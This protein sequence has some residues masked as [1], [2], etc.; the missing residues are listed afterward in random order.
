MKKLTTQEW[1]EK[2]RKIHGDKFDYSQTQYLTAKIPIKIICP[3]HGAFYTLPHNHLKPN[4]GC[5]KCRYESSTVKQAKSKDQFIKDA[6]FVHGDKYDYS[7]VKYVNNTTK[8]CIICPI[9]GEFW[10]APTKH[11]DAKQGCPSCSGNKKRSTESFIADAIKIHGNKYDYSKV[12]YKGAHTHVVITCPKHGDF[13]QCPNEHLHGQGCP[14]CKETKGEKEI[15]QM[16]DKLNIKYEYQYKYD[17]T[18]K[19]YSIDYYLPQHNIGIECQGQQHFQGVDFSGNGIEW[20][21]NEFEKNIQRDKRKAQSC[22]K[23]KINLIY[24]IPPQTTINEGEIFDGNGIYNNSNTFFSLK[25]IA[26][27]LNKKG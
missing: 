20:A 14:H 27:F 10:Q 9:H 23:S 11:I 25:E 1:I 13:K 24:Y 5:S 7:K 6:R 12:D 4:G 18:N 21:Q 17:D 15:R 8:V 26:N 16:L 19:K 2:V 3:K 22:Q